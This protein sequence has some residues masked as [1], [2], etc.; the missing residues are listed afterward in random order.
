P[1][2]TLLIPHD[3]QHEEPTILAK[4]RRGERVSHFETKRRRKDGTLLDISL[5]ISP[6]KDSLGQIIGASK[7]ARDI[8][9]QVTI[10]NALRAANQSLR[11]LNGDLEQFAYSA[12]HDLQEPLRMVSIYAELA[13][14]EYASGESTR[15]DEYLGV[16]LDASERMHR[17][18]ADL[19]TYTHASMADEGPPQSVDANLILQRVLKNLAP[20]ITESEAAITAGVLPFVPMHEFQ[21]EQLLQN[22]IGNAVRYRGDSAP[23]IRVEAQPEGSRWRFSVQDNGIGIEP[24]YKEHVFGLFRRLHTSAAYPGNGM[25]L[26]ICKRIVERT[27]GRIWVESEPRKGSTFFFVVPGERTTPATGEPTTSTRAVN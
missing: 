25:G 22:L 12:S 3:R 23:V 14:E 2:A 19:R 1:V 8:T 4:L 16:V 9:E 20:A 17:L 6:V 10:R 26:A 27:D 21:L 18:L 24:E 5:T 15:G 13:R 11:R 7:I